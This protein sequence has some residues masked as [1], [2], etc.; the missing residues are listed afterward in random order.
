MFTSAMFQGIGHGF[1]S[2]VVSILRTIVM[3]VLFS[4]LFVFVFGLGLNGVW[5]GILTG[6]IVAE[7]ITFLWGLSVTVRLKLLF[8]EKLKEAESI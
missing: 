4:Y 3:H 5:L 8:S 2:L 6:N 7:A 1:K